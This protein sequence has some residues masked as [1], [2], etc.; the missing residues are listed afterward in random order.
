M[1]IARPLQDYRGLVETCRQ[2]ADE[3]SLSRLE[4]DRLAGLPEGYSGKLLGSGKGLKPKRMWPASL[5]AIL[6]TL[7]LKLIVV[8][9]ETAA[10]N[11]CTTGAHDRSGQPKEKGGQIWVMSPQPVRPNERLRPSTPQCPIPHSVQPNAFR[12]RSSPRSAC[13]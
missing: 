5:E 10:A 11:C 2:R 9:D 8:E 6:G 4:L 1:T 13:W 12:K 3:L 7:G